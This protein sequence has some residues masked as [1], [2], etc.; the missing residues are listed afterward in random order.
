MPLREVGKGLESIKNFSRCMNRSTLGNTAFNAI[1]EELMTAYH[2][3]AV[4]SMKNAAEEI[5]SSAVD[6]DR[7]GNLAKCCVSFD[8]TWQK[9]G[10]ASLNGV[11]T[12][13]RYNGKCLDYHVLSKYCRGCRTWEN[14]KGTAEYNKWKVTHVC[15]L[16][17]SRSSGAMEAAGAVQ[18]FSQSVEINKLIYHEY[19]GDGDTSSFKEVI[20]AKPYAEFNLT[21]VGH[22]H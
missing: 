2:Q 20:D 3:V 22:V 12:A 6:A 4:V 8:G 21:P 14:K 13:I 15:Q 11:V 5:K 17:H 9:R 18:I 10:H 7:L 19:F 1:N 16:N